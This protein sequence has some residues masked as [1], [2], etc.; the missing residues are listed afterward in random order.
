M[1]GEFLAIQTEACLE[2]Q[3]AGL[4]W[5]RP[6]MSGLEVENSAGVIN[7]TGSCLRYSVVLPKPHVR[8]TYL[9]NRLLYATTPHPLGCQ[10]T[11][12]ETTRAFK[13]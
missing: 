6:C 12:R 13:C 3:H 5:I 7:T 10:L 2:S 8:I 11:S 1:L 4:D 9:N